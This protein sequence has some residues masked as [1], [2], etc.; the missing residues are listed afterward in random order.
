M[1]TESALLYNK[2]QTVGSYLKLSGVSSGGDMENIIL[3]RADGSALSNEE[4]F[5]R[6]NKILSTVV[7][8][9]DTIVVPEKVNKESTWNTIVRN[10]KDYTQVLYQLGL[11]AAAFKSLR[12]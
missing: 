3:V 1:N 11:G 5:W 10:A 12:N 6:D 7:M 2:G 9:G 8:P 4:K